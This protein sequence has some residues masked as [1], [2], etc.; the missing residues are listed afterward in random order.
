[1]CKDDVIVSE[2]VARRQSTHPMAGSAHSLPLKLKETSWGLYSGQGTDQGFLSCGT[3]DIPLVIGYRVAA[4]GDLDRIW[5]DFET[6]KSK[7]ACVTRCVCLKG[8]EI[9]IR[10]TEM[11]TSVTFNVKEVIAS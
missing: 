4:S 6:P 8:H 10:E 1:M 3:S 7:V 2:L 5:S 11:A 9:G